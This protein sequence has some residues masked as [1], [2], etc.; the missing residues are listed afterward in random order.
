MTIRKIEVPA[1]SI[2]AALRADAAKSESRVIPCVFSTGARGLRYGKIDGQWLIFHEELSLDPAHVRLD[3]LNNGAPVLNAHSSWS[4]EQ[5]L[6]VVDRAWLTTE[7]GVQLGN[8]DLRM[9]D[10]PQVAWV[11]DEMV[12]RIITHVSVGYKPFKYQLMGTAED[13]YPIYR[14]VLWEPMEISPVPMGF[15]DKSTT[16]SLRGLDQAGLELLH[17]EAKSEFFACEVLDAERAESINNHKESEDMKV[18]INGQEVRDAAGD[19]G[20]TGGGTTPVVDLNKVRDEAAAE[21]RAAERVRIESIRALV[22]KHEFEDGLAAS[23]IERGVSLDNAREQVLEKLVARDAAAAT[24]SQQATVTHGDRDEVTTFRSSMALAIV[25]RAM[26][27][28]FGEVRDDSRKFM[29]RRLEDLARISLERAG[30]KTDHLSPSEICKRAMTTGDLPLIL[31][32]AQNKFMRRGY[33]GASSEWKRLGNKRTATDYKAINNLKLSELGDLEELK[34]GAKIVLGYLDEGKEEY[35][36]V[37]YAKMLIITD[38]VLINDDLRSLEGVP[39]RFGRAAMRLEKTIFTRQITANAAM[40]DAVALFH[41]THGNLAAG[42][43]VG[44]IS[45]ASLGLARKAIRLQKELGAS[46]PMGLGTKF[47]VVPAALE[48]L[49]EQF[50]ATS[51]KINAKKADEVNPFAGRLEPIVLDLL[52]ASSATAWY[53]FCDPAEY[54]TIEYAY[55]EGKEGPMIDMQPSFDEKG[56]KLKVEHTFGAGVQ[57]HRGMYKNPGA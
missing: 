32:D 5:I 46:A 48:T 9:S 41:A 38:R 12:K 24:R 21:A 33:D 6:G 13:G 20:G 44:A 15:D 1:M 54:D 4:L 37:D 26:P 42:G 50:V 2:R 17:R 39:T 11:Y 45:V 49:A 43:D 8:A 19:A 29:H 14:C 40:A 30:I 3:R 16:R 35:T 27:N 36:I 28:T 10:R 52:D 51:V 22:K 34:E 47:L 18:R 57:D 56:L 55:L 7:A 25:H 53:G 31:A 23:L